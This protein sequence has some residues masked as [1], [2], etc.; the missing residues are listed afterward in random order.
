MIMVDELK[1]HPGARRP[2]HL[3]SCHLTTDGN[4]AELHAFAARLGMRRAWFQDHRIAPHY[5]LTPGRRQLAL[6]QG[7]CFVSA[8]EQAM[9]RRAKKAEPE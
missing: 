1:V 6:Q 9:R 4:L 5:D 7:A 2:F 8:R 3:G